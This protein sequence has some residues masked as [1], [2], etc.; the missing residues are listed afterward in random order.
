LVYKVA[1]ASDCVVPLTSIN[2]R[3]AL[4]DVVTVIDADITSASDANARDYVVTLTSIDN[5]KVGEAETILGSASSSRNYVF[6]IA[7]I[8]NSCVDDAVT[9]IGA[10]ASD[11]VVTILSIEGRRVRDASNTNTSDYVVASK[12]ISDAS[13]EYFLLPRQGDNIILVSKR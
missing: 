8:D 5:G 13:I 3:V 12:S 9:I 6:S 10:I 2:L 11:Y 1:N 4:S 7:S